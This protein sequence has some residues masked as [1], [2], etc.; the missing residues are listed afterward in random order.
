[1][2][3]LVILRKTCV[4]KPVLC[5]GELLECFAELAFVPGDGFGASRL[6]SGG[7][8]VERE[9]G[10]VGGVGTELESARGGSTGEGVVEGLVDLGR[11][12]GGVDFGEVGTA[13][14]ASSPGG[15]A[16]TNGCRELGDALL[17]LS[18]SI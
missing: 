12:C 14:S 2:S 10:E 1:M 3:N 7:G 17:Q 5:N 6:R 4:A 18:L 8:G 9:T 16:V 13:C 15:D 11:R